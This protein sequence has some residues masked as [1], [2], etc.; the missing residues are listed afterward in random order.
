MIGAVPFTPQNP[1]APPEISNPEGTP[2]GLTA[3]YIPLRLSLLTL[4]KPN[5][6]LTKSPSYLSSLELLQSDRECYSDTPLF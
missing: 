1:R 6:N 4:S 3:L 2:Q 5:P